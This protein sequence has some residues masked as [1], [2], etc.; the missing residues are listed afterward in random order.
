MKIIAQFSFDMDIICCPDY[1]V[2]DLE[3]YK[4][5]FYV[6]LYDKKN[7]HPYWLQKNGKKY[8]CLYR[9]QAFVDWLNE[10]ILQNSKEK[11]TV[12]EECIDSNGEVIKI[13]L[14]QDVND[15]NSIIENKKK[16]FL[17][18]I[19]LLYE[20]KNTRENAYI[21]QYGLDKYLY[22]ATVDWVN[23][24]ILSLTDKR[25]YVIEKQ[26]NI[27]TLKNIPIIYF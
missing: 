4:E 8:S 9:S 20:D 19:H 10:F 2:N 26:I 23:E 3:T 22:Y 15:L 14:P 17:K 7:N 24:V 11:A 16:D 27:E 25:A 18:W 12:V 5:N 13:H 21:K 6:W 1:I